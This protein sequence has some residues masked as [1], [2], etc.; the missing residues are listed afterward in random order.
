MLGDKRLIQSIMLQN[1]LSFGPDAAEI[2]LKSLNVLIGPNASGKSNLIEAL[3][4]LRASPVDLGLLFEREILL[5]GS[6]RVLDSP[7][8]EVNATIRYAG[9]SMPL[10]HRISFTRVGQRFELADESVEDEHPD[11]KQSAEVRFYY[12]YHKGHPVIRA[13][14]EQAERGN[15]RIRSRRKLRRED[16]ALDQSILSQRKDR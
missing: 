3:G 9:G 16:L 13:Y 15:R 6:E 8:G 1:F 14:S 7:D 2:E 10:R 12:R 11:A 5:G 4:F